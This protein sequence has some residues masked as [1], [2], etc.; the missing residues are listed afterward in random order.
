MIKLHK[1]Q[2]PK[3]RHYTNINIKNADLREFVSQV[4]AITGK[5][6]VVDP[7]IKG[8]VTVI[9]NT[10]MD[11]DA[12]Y[13]LFLSV[14]RVHNFIAMPSGDVIRVIPNAQ[15]KQTPGPDG[16]LSAIASEELVTRV[17]AAQNVESAELVKILRPLIPQSRRLPE[18]VRPKR[19]PATP[20]CAQNRG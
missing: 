8:N 19:Y 2:N 9:S 7:R 12:V 16:D 6:F 5:T 15:G 11:Q 13:A 4:A 20:D 18:I 14:L 17:V 3:C 1:C 10:A